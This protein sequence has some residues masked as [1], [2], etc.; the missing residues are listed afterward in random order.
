MHWGSN[1][2]YA[3]R[4][5]ATAHR[6]RCACVWDIDRENPLRYFSRQ[7]K[8]GTFHRDSVGVVRIA[9]VQKTFTHNIHTKLSTRTLIDTFFIFESPSHSLFLCVLQLKQTERVHCRDGVGR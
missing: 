6:N 8:H 9:Y 7:L 4:L 1:A 2:K 5:F 3:G